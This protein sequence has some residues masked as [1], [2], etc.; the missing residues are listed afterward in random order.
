VPKHVQGKRTEGAKV[1][2]ALWLLVAMAVITAVVAAVIFEE[3]GRWQPKG[4]R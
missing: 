1:N 3:R 2:P 4:R